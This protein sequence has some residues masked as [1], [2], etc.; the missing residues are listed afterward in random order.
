MDEIDLLVICAEGLPP[1]Q[2]LDL[3]RWWMRTGAELRAFFNH[4]SGQWWSY[5]RAGEVSRYLAEP[6]LRTT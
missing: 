1:A 5:H 6:H 4:R 2:M 3:L